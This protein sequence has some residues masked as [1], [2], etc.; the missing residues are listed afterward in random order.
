MPID[1]IES[2][3]DLAECVNGLW[4]LPRPYTQRQLRTMAWER[5]SR[6]S[7][8]QV[9]EAIEFHR[10]Q[11]PDEPKPKWKAIFAR[12]RE[13]SKREPGSQFQV[14]LNSLRAAWRKLKVPNV[15]EMND[16][17]VWQHWLDAQTYPITHDT[18]TKERKPDDEACTHCE[19]LAQKYPDK[20]FTDATPHRAGQPFFEPCN[21]MRLACEAVRLRERE[22]DYWVETFRARGT[23]PPSFLLE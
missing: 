1:P 12:L 8:T 15:D 14:F 2:V 22:A 3:E 19:G 6:Y 10:F 9:R 7:G 16:A 5:L 21:R 4:S 20:R 18:L 11:Q 23:E 17:N 13:K